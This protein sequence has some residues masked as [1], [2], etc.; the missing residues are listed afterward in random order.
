MN[1]KEKV[2]YVLVALAGISAAVLVYAV[3]TGSGSVEDGRGI[4]YFYSPN[5][6]Y[7][8]QVKP[9]IEEMAKKYP[10]VFCQIE[11]LSEDCKNI[12]EKAKIKYIPTVVVV[13]ESG[14]TVLTGVNQVL[15][16]EEVVKK[17]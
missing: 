12:E 7:C 11:S 15:Q 14:M 2:I 10:I 8:Q 9:F 4:Y 1:S 16:L 3:A 13:S 5:C 6:H 17:Q